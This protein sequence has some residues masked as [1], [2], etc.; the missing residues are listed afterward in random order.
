[1]LSLTLC[2]LASAR[3]QLM[4]LEEGAKPAQVQAAQAQVR[5]AETALYLAQLQ[6]DKALVRAPISGVVAS[7]NTP[8]R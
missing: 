8:G 6:L 7:V 1:M 5:Q 4:R 3:A 2:A